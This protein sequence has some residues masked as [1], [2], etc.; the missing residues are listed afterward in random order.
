MT[1]TIKVHLCMQVA[2]FVNKTNPPTSRSCFHLSSSQ[3]KILT[4]FVNILL[5]TRA[6]A[7]TYNLC[8]SK[9]STDCTFVR[10]DYCILLQALTHHVCR[11]ASGTPQSLDSAVRQI[12]Q[13]SHLCKPRP[14]P[15]EG[16][17]RIWSHQREESTESGHFL[18]LSIT[19]SSTRF[20]SRR[21]RRILRRR[22]RSGQ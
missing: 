12:V 19:R 20:V 4:G 3:T 6:S 2:Q 10:L 7:I 16:A 22:R 17:R 5:Y 9:E 21:H 14:P 15:T 8:R 1:L 13:Y 18:H 11:L